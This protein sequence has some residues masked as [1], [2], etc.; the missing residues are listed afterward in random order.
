MSGSSM[1]VRGL[2]KQK[3]DVRD[4]SFDRHLKKDGNK[5]KKENNIENKYSDDIAAE[6]IEESSVDSGMN[7]RIGQ[8][9]KY[10]QIIDV[11]A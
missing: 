4:R 6:Q 8:N 1:K 7:E 9:D 2:Y 11:L 3:Q 10:K 5:K